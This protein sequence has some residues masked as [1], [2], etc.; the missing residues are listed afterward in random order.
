MEAVD[1]DDP[2]DDEVEQEESKFKEILYIKR[3]YKTRCE[4]STQ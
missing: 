4:A 1:K 3:G 2:M